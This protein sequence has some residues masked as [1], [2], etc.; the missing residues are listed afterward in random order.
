V[1]RRVKLVGMLV[2]LLVISATYILATEFDLLLEGN[3]NDFRKLPNQTRQDSGFT[4]VRLMYNGRIP[5][6]IK[7]WYTD[8]P[9][10]DENLIHVLQRMTDIDVAP[11]GRVIPIHHPDLFNY[12]MIYS[13]EA[14]QM[15]FDDSD[16]AVLRE[17][18]SRG[19]FWMID[20]FWGTFE[21]ANFERE[22]RKVFPDRPIVEI[23]PSH[24]IFHAVYD[25]NEK[26]Q[27]PNV[28][29]AYTANAVTWEQDG[30]EPYVRGIFDDNGRL[31]VFINF[32]TDLMDASEWSDDPKYP[33]YFSAYSYKVFTNAVV[34]ALSH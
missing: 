32:N 13:A 29:Y 14:G 7:N 22:I 20:D 16:G 9:T 26:M 2:P 15:V 3:I 24:P 4:F 31:L 5:G 11:E 33:Q 21:W 12:P 6:Y 27:V 18:L 1:N 19:G 25:I 34:Y 30:Y 17:Y 10:G 8:Y 28:G 23:P